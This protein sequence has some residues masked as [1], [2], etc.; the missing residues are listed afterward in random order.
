MKVALSMRK[1]IYAKTRAEE[2]EKR[3]E[4]RTEWAEGGSRRKPLR[5]AIDQ[6]TKMEEDSTEEK[7]ANE[8]DR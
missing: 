7:R 3:R 5:T 4:K 2:M 8:T 1:C 6:R